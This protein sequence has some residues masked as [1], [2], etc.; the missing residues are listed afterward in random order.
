MGK[1]VKSLVGEVLVD[2]CFTNGTGS[3]FYVKEL[4]DDGTAYCLALDYDE[5][6]ATQ[7]VVVDATSD[8]ELI[9]KKEFLDTLIDLIKETIKY[10]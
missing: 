9:T 3:Y 4:D 6:R 2:K 7:D 5:I 10:E 8:L 1:T